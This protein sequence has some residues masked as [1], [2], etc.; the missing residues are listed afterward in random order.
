M[1]ESDIV[2]Y[3]Y[4]VNMTGIGEIQ[5]DK[6]LSIYPL[7]LGEYLNI[8]NG[9]KSIDSVYIFDIN[10]KL[11]L[12]SGKSEKQVSLNVGFLTPGIYILNVKTNGQSIINKIIKR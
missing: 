8:A 11:M 12:H 1:I 6:D 5:I 7:P 10:G 9:D 3:Q 4:T 2:E